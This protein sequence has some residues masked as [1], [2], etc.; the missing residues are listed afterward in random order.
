MDLPNQCC[1]NVFNVVVRPEITVHLASNG[2]RVVV[3]RIADSE[4]AESLSTSGSLPYPT[5]LSAGSV[6]PTIVAPT[7]IWPSCTTSARQVAMTQEL[8]PVPR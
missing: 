1:G 8:S 3:V 6:P 2:K 5:V 4:P 7:A